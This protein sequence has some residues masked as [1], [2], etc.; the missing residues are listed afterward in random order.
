MQ[1]SPVNAK[2]VK[3]Y[4]LM[5]KA[6]YRQTCRRTNKQTDKWTDGQTGLY[7]RV[8]ATKKSDAD[9]ELELRKG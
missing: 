3:K 9:I 2:K 1:Y 6:T 7:S 5:D 4:S 8:H